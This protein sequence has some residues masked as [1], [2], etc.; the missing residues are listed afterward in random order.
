MNALLSATGVTKQFGGLLAV[1]DVTLD[2][3]GGRV[4]A[5]IGPNGAGKTTL[6][7]CLTGMIEPDAG[8]VSL[9]DHD[10][11]AW[12]VPR[13]A[14]AGLGRTFQR[15]EV[16]VAMTVADNL[17]VAAEAR[18]ARGWLR[19]VL[20]TADPS[21]V[22]VD[23]VVDRSLHALAL[24]DVANVRAGELSTGTLRRLEVARAL[25]TEPRVL[26]LDEPASGLD[27]AETDGLGSLLQR[28]ADDGLAVLLIE[29]DM[30]LVMEAS[31]H[32]V[33][34]DRGRVIA[35]GSPDQVATD[36]AVRAA[37]LGESVHGGRRRGSVAGD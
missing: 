22:H 32:V 25:C 13:R 17:R 15:L 27:H 26:L 10:V 14:L 6:F 12:D 3:P 36:E 11:T 5:L 4:T 16:F 28:L 23:E 37:Y 8:T 21:A 18:S 24:Q 35:E 7:N 9:V 29:H 31:S 2:V 1:D 20:G 33:V 30:R 19:D 34:L